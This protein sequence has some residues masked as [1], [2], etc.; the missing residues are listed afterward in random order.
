M[1]LAKPRPAPNAETNQQIS[2]ARLLKPPFLPK[3]AAR[4]DLGTS[5]FFFHRARRILFRQD[6]KEWG[7]HP[8][9]RDPGDFRAE[10]GAKAAAFAASLP[11]MAGTRAVRRT[12]TPGRVHPGPER[13]HVAINQPN[14]KTTR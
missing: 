7:V 9:H 3:P 12:P 14:R 2:G 8:P 1:G 11:A 6:E 4:Q 10:S 13:P 5:A